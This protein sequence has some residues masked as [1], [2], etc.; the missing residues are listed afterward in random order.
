[1]PD[2]ED[3]QG[4]AEEPEDED[5][6]SHEVPPFWLCACAAHRLARL[7]GH[8]KINWIPELLTETARRQRL[9]EGVTLDG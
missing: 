5:G 8:L 7:M 2:H 3:P 6:T 1:M 9:R 4:E